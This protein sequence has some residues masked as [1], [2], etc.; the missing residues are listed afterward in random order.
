MDFSLDKLKK[1]AEG[2]RRLSYEARDEIN[3]INDY[4][5]K[6]S[7]VAMPQSAPVSSVEAIQPQMEVNVKSATP[8]NIEIKPQTTEFDE[9][10]NAIRNEYLDTIRDQF[11]RDED[12]FNDNLATFLKTRFGNRFG[13][14][15]IRR[16]HGDSG[17]I[18]INGKYVLEQKYADNPGL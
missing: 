8:V 16:R 7:T 3:A 10:F 5:G 11:F 18:L 12:A 17:D 1:Y 13:I 6:S 15:N 2:D 4:L 9:I 14:E